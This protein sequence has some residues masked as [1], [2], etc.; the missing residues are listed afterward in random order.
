MTVAKR[1]SEWPFSHPRRT[2]GP[3][4]GARYRE[5]DR[6]TAMAAASDGNPPMQPAGPVSWCRTGTAS[7]AKDVGI[8]IALRLFTVRPLRPRSARMWPV[9][10]DGFPALASAQDRGGAVRA[11]SVED[12]SPPPR[13]RAPR[14]AFDKAPDIAPRWQR[15][16]CGARPV[17][18]HPSRPACGK[19]GVSP[20][21]HS[22][23]PIFWAT[24]ICLPQMHCP[25]L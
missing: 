12:G 19:P 7:A 24:I 23:G 15:A 11:G 2:A 6:F 10:M 3:E 13:N 1:F 9:A 14:P 22:A 20:S 18:A 17:L 16:Q 8:G 4:S 5:R 25:P 21:R